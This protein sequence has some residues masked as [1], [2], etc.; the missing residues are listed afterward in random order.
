MNKNQRFE[1]FPHIDLFFFPTTI[2]SFAQVRILK[3]ILIFTLKS[4]SI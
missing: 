1:L 2:G 3:I 4:T